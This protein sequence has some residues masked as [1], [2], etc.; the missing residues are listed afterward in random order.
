MKKLIGYIDLLPLPER[1]VNN[2]LMLITEGT[3]P[4]ARKEGRDILNRAMR[5][6]YARWYGKDRPEYKIEGIEGNPTGKII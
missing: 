5:I 2:C 4:E 1:M 6:A 3:T